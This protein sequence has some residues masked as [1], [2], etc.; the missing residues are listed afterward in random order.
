MS[1]IS[2]MNIKKICPKTLQNKK[3]IKLKNYFLWGGGAYIIKQHWQGKKQQLYNEY[4]FLKN[5][6]FFQLLITRDFLFE[7]VK[8]SLGVWTYSLFAT[9]CLISTVAQRIISLYYKIWLC[10]FF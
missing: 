4:Q 6:S 5:F 1:A 8:N 9:V 10:L 7:K 2:N 3:L